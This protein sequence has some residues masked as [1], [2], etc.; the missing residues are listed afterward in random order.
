MQKVTFFNG[1]YTLHGN[2]KR[3]TPAPMQ[4]APARAYTQ[5]QKKVLKA[6]LDGA[7]LH[8][9][10]DKYRVRDPKL[11]PLHRLSIGGFLQIR[12]YLRQHGE[13]FK[14]DPAK[15]N[16]ARPNA[17]VKQYLLTVNNASHGN[18]VPVNRND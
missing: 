2:F 11:K 6:L 16:Q 18:S 4:P 15:V 8:K 5:H 1:N 12:R 7:A 9:D 17:W 14:I 13:V 3:V 10:G